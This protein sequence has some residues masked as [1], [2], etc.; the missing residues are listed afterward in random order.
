[1]AWRKRVPLI[2]GGIAKIVVSLT[3]CGGGGTGE[4]PTAR[5]PTATTPGTAPAHKPVGGELTG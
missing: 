5:N 4:E 2:P 1:M 3:A